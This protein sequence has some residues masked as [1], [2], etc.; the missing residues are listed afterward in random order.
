MTHEQAQAL[1]SL[2]FCICELRVARALI[3]DQVRGT[4]DPKYDLSKEWGRT[5]KDAEE[6]YKK[7]Q[8]ELNNE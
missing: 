2:Y 1:N 4:N 6:G 5:I 7:L 8:R 3:S